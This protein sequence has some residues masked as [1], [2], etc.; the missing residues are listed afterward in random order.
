MTI[1]RSEAASRRVPFRL[2]LA[3]S[4]SVSLLLCLFAILTPP[5][6]AQ[7]T[8][9][10]S[11]TSA[12]DGAT[13]PGAAPSM[14]LPETEFDYGEANPGTTITHDFVVK[15]EG[16]APLLITD[17]VPGCGCTVTS[18]TSFI[19]PGGEGLVTMNVDLYKEW[20]GRDV[21]KAITVLSNDPTRPTTRLVMRTKVVDE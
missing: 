17:V 12:V 15:N 9:E 8:N 3:A 18:F 19:R 5:A 7:E 21:N 14:A 11:A 6:F 2:G 1:E 20:V 10:G 13:P 4:L 16:T